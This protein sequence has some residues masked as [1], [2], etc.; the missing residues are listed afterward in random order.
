MNRPKKYRETP[1]R[2]PLFLQKLREGFT[3]DARGRDVRPDPVHH[4]HAEREENTSTQ[5]GDLE[6]ILK[7]GQ[8]PFKHRR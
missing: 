3:V 5:L 2:P 4:E 1:A 8:E 7:T 6:D